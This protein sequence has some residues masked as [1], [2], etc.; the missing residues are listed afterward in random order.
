MYPDADSFPAGTTVT[1]LH[2]VYRVLVT[3]AET[4]GAL[5]MFSAVVA[6][7][8]GPPRHVHH[9]EDETI[10]VVEGEV[11]FWLDGE[12]FVRGPG[13][14]VFVPRGKEHGFFVLSETPARFVTCVTPGGFESF[15]A[16]AATRGLRIPE[17]R[18][19]LDA[20]AAAYGCAFTGPPIAAAA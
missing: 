17:H 9:N 7:R 15:F 13:D 10:T 1:W 5:G 12:S 2:S 6:P 20:L 16:S 3:P 8:S 14:A 18:V 11:R 4:G 19:E